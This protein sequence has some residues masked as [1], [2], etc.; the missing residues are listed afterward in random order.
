LG[1]TFN[2]GLDVASG[3]LACPLALGDGPLFSVADENWELL[4]AGCMPVTEFKILPLKNSHK[5]T[6]AAA[7][8]TTRIMIILD[9]FLFFM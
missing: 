6:A 8:I 7:A 9:F 4:G 3:V 1:S 2:I 5:N